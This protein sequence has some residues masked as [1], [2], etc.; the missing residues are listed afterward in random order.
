MIFTDV[1]TMLTETDSLEE[2]SPPVPLPLAAF[3]AEL[4]DPVPP[5]EVEVAACWALSD[6][7][8]PRWW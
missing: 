1:V 2:P 5:V 3:E 7:P 6:M 4:V 8:E